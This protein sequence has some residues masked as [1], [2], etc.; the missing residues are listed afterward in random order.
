M[1]IYIYIYI[2]LQFEKIDHV[3]Y[4][5]THKVELLNSVTYCGWVWGNENW[6]EEEEEANYFDNICQDIC[7]A[8]EPGL[9]RSF[10]CSQLSYFLWS[11]GKHTCIVGCLLCCR[12]CLGT[13]Y[14]SPQGCGFM[15]SLEPEGSCSYLKCAEREG[16]WETGL[17]S[18]MPRLL[19]NEMLI[20]IKIE[21]Q[22]LQDFATFSGLM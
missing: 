21:Q 8:W 7:Q 15:A 14:K 3:I 10:S 16:S 13:E 17:W 20:A 18:S 19:D 1:Y 22:F 6:K 9:E 12:A 2:Y 4:P 11:F 5:P